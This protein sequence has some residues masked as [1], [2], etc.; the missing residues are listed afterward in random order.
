MFSVFLVLF[1][2]MLVVSSSLAGPTRQTKGLMYARLGS[3]LL[4][5]AKDRRGAYEQVKR[6][7]SN[8]V[9]VRNIPSPHSFLTF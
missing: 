5:G 2:L 9:V 3:G 8:R 4:H 6:N 1:V 7:K